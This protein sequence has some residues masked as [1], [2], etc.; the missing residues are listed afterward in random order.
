VKKG[1]YAAFPSLPFLNP[2]VNYGERSSNNNPL[3]G[4]GADTIKSFL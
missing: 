3:L 1:D 2:Y 4:V